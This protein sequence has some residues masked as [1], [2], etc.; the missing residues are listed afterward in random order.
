MRRMV[1]DGRSRARGG[2]VLVALALVWG[3]G[4]DKNPTGPDGDPDP[5]PSNQAPVAAAGPDGAVSVGI[6]VTVDASGSTDSDGDALT[7]AWTLAPPATSAAALDDAASETPSFVPDVEGAYVLSLT[8]NDGTDDSAADE[9]TITAT[10]N[11]ATTSMPAAI[12]GS[13]TSSDGAMTMTVPA[14]ALSA[15]TDI[16]VTPL[17]DVQIPPALRGLPGDLSV[18]DLQPDGTTFSTPVEVA[19][20]IDGA[21]TNTSGSAAMSGAFLLSESD[22]TIEGMTEVM[23]VQDDMDPA[24]ATISGGLSHFSSALFVSMS[25]EFRLDAPDEVTLDE[26]FDVTFTIDITG[27]GLD[28]IRTATVEDASAAPVGPFEQT[29]PFTST[30]VI[31]G[32]E[33]T[34]T[35]SY[36]CSEEAE[37][38]IRANFQFEAT[39]EAFGESAGSVVTVQLGKNVTCKAPPAPLET[40]IIPNLYRAQRLLPV[41]GS[42]TEITTGGLVRRVDLETKAVTELSEPGSDPEWVFALSDGNYLVH[43]ILGSVDWFVPNATPEDTMFVSW[44]DQPRHVTPVSENTV[45]LASAFGDL[46]F[47]TYTPGGASGSFQD[48]FR[49]LE[50][51]TYP[52]QDPAT[53]LQA[54]WVSADAQTFIGAVTE[55]DGDSAFNKT[56]AALLDADVQSGQ[57]SVTVLPGIIDFILDPVKRH[58]FDL[59]C[60]DLEGGTASELLCVFTS[61]FDGPAASGSDP[62]MDLQDD[63]YVAIFTVD[64]FDQSSEL[65]FWDIGNA[66]VG[67]GIFTVDGSTTGVAVA[68]Q[69][70]EALDVWHVQGKEVA[71][72]FFVSLSGQCEAPTDLILLGAGARGALACQASTPSAHSILVI[73]NLDERQPPIS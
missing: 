40:T 27:A 17:G 33:A 37:A 49:N 56:Q 24:K 45:A 34:I 15:D 30:M 31:S 2:A 16:S 71:A 54:I 10:D 73:E 13:M 60:G 4:S 22:G 69:F 41:P 65:L 44:Y 58:Q 3:C 7:Y 57:I 43:T 48:A 72:S 6:A 70:T 8:V 19:F 39:D 29:E 28:N 51:Q 68:N 18:Y 55:G 32:D 11:T 38:R 50:S 42:E 21:V 35:N 14:G 9:A 20:E 53:N 47:M 66:R 67:A 12:G 59:E 52:Q 23:L 61:G 36:V 63:G 25:M 62:N 26:P 64:S 1:L 5:T 46:G